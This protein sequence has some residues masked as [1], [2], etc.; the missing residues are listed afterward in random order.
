ME[1][2]RDIYL[3]RLIRREKNGLIKIVTGVRRCG[4]S[5]L[6]FNLFHHYLLEKGVRE[7]HIIEVAL[8][9]R[10]NKELRD[11]DNM[12]KYVKERIVDK[13]TYYI[14]LDEVQLLA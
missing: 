11:P 13:E 1:I 5:Y 6:L 9:D 7:D 8:D 3:D 10:S 12:L 2:K 4:K 14:I